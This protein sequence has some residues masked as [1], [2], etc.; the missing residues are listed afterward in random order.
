[1]SLVNSNAFPYT[2]F[3]FTEVAAAASTTIAF[4]GYQ[5]PSFFRLDDVN[6]SAGFAAVPLPG[7][8]ALLGSG[9]LP[10]LGWRR[11]RKS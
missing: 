11:F 7:T 4:A 9:L 6:V 2:H 1:M 5:V 3:T 10:L 8:L